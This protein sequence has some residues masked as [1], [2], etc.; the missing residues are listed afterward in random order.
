MLSQRSGRLGEFGKTTGRLHGKTA[1][2]D[3][4][5]V[6]VGSMNL[7]GRSASLNTEIGLVIDS[8]EIAAD[9][10]R[11]ISI[12]RYTSAYLVRIGATGGVEWVEQD[13][14]GTTTAVH[15][16]EPETSWFIKS[17]NWLLSP[18]VAEELL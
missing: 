6:F 5:R 1:V 18:F 17:K 13:S 4:K 11:I 12:D 15:E 2:I 8:P 16:D 3:D 14:N 7:D 10:N 9:I